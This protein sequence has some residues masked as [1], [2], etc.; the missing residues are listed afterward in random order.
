M[1]WHKSK[2]NSRCPEIEFIAVDKKFQ[3]IGIGSKLIESVTKHEAVIG[4]T[5]MTKTSNPLAKNIYE[6]K[7]NAIISYEFLLF[8]K[9]YWYL[10][11]KPS[12]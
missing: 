6:K 7:Y 9:K 10:T 12:I 2:L 8:G 4:A 5:L 11:W 1:V 3:G